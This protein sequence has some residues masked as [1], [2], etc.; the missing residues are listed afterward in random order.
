MPVAPTYPGV[1]VQEIS[2]G[3]RTI[4]GVSTSTA[5]FLGPAK[6]GPINKATRV[7]SFG[8]YER[9]FGGLDRASEMSYAVRQFF[10]NGG[11][12]AWIVRL[13]KNAASASRKLQNEAAKEVLEVTAVCEGSDGNNIEL[14]VD[15][16]TDNPGTTFNLH[17]AS[18]PPNDPGARVNEAFPNLSMNSKDS[19]YVETVVNSTSRLVRVTRMAKIDALSAGQA[20][21]KPLIDGAKLEDLKAKLSDTCKELRVIV[22]GGDPIQVT[23]EPASIN[24]TPD[25]DKWL[26][27]VC[28]QI[29]AKVIDALGGSSTFTCKRGSYGTESKLCRIV[30]TSPTNKETSSVRAIPATRNDASTVLGFAAHDG[31]AYVDAVAGIRP[32]VV[33]ERGK[34]TGGAIA[35]G[36]LP[37][38]VSIGPHNQV[39]IIS[40]DGGSAREVNLGTFAPSGSVVERVTAVAAKIQSAV[41]SL[42]SIDPAYQDFTCEVSVSTPPAPPAPPSQVVRLVLASGTRGSKA[43]VAVCAKTGDTLAD[44]LKLVTGVTITS[45]PDILL[46]G[47][48]EQ[49]FDKTDELSV[50]LESQT[51]RRGIYA[52]DEVDIFNIMCLPAVTDSGVLAAAA[53]YCQDRRAFLIVDAPSSKT[54]AE[55][56]QLISGP[57]LPKSEYAA[58]YYPWIRVRDPLANGALRGCPPC[59]AI[60]GI[61]A[62]TDLTRGVWKAPAG[63]ETN[64]SGVVGLDYV[65]TDL[66]QGVLNPL[67]VNCLRMF[68]VISSVNWGARTLRGA[69]QLT[70]EYK[71]VPIRRLALFIEESLFRGLKWVV[72]EPNDE[73]LW[74]NVRMNVKAFLHDL[75]R[76]GAFA[77]LTP[78]EAY[79]VRCDKETTTPNDQNL[80]IVNIWVG[81]APLKPA[82]FVVLSIQQIQELGKKE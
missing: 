63:I 13:A 24:A 77:G 22:D 37:S 72:F 4:V 26:D 54:P 14:K 57:D 69:D 61:Y 75:F 17:V 16:K 76:K 46:T 58:V 59:G 2:S 50:Y 66:E 29:Q 7:L 18:V 1:Y 51:N 3:V 79:F 80:G 56:E 19:R 81:F 67:G 48:Y 36:D 41:R 34:L 31:R 64:L 33:P 8:D 15:H 32:K 62:R 5:A 74:A 35:E 9:V 28:K 45:A 73:P 39:L 82:E 21:S 78:Q 71:Y 42:S 70:S 6:K 52:L 11:S 53:K 47:G 49:S 38:T 40:L 23:L 55:M 27:E 68:P 30:M 43:S 25:A 20:Y 10:E 44:K 65:L 60:A 12:I